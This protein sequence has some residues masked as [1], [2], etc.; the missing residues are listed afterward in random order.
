MF[1]AE[2]FDALLKRALNRSRNEFPF[3]IDVLHASC[4]DD[5]ASGFVSQAPPG[6]DAVTLTGGMVAMIA[7]I[8]AQIS[9]LLGDDMAAHLVDQIW[10]DMQCA[11]SRANV[12]RVAE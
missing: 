1:G 6:V 11:E 5:R 10:P 9:R 12:E 7:T 2:G 3:L 8:V 4:A